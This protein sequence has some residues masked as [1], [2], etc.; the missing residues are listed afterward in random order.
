MHLRTKLGRNTQDNFL[1]RAGGLA[2]STRNQGFSFLVSSLSLFGSQTQAYLY[3]W[4][5]PKKQ[6]SLKACAW[7]FW[8]LTSSSFFF[9]FFYIVELQY[10]VSSKYRAKW[11]DYT[12]FFRLF[13]IIGYYKILDIIP[14]AIQVGPCWLSILCIAVCIC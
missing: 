5:T 6:K 9:S 7:M 1:H 10:C 14:C 13:S 12:Y 3:C 2:G 8:N 11:F 4:L